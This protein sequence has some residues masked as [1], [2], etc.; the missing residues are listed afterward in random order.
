MANKASRAA[1]FAPFEA[2]GGFGAKIQQIEEELSRVE[3]KELSDD[4]VEEISQELAKIQRGS[5]IQVT[6]YYGGHYVDLHTTVLEKNVPFKYIAVENSK[7]FFDDIL[8]LHV[9]RI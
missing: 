8:T 1:Q 3:K 6:F 2:L 4:A 7:I 5:V 9:E